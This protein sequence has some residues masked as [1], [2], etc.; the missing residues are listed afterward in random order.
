MKYV[1]SPAQVLIRYPIQRG[2]HVIPKSVNPERISANIQVFDFE[3][4]DDEMKKLD[5]LNKNRR[6]ID[7]ASMSKSLGKHKYYPWV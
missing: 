6:Y 5:N 2:L 7:I 3:L 4:T 1:K